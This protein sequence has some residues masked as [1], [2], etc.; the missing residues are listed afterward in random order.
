M[1]FRH[2]HIPVGDGSLHIAEA[3]DPHGRP[4]LFLH[5]WPQSWRA[6]QGVMRHAAPE[7]R[8]VAVDLPGIG[9]STTTSDGTKSHVAD[10]VHELVTAMG[11]RGATLVGHDAGGMAAYSYL[12]RYRDVARVAILDVVVPGVPP[13]EAVVR[14]PSV[15]HFGFHATPGLPETLTRGRQAVYFDHFFDI[16][17]VDHARITPQARAAYAAAYGSDAA[18][19]AGFDLYRAFPED[20]RHNA[21]YGASQPVATPLLYVRGEHSGGDIGAYAEGFHGAGITQL[22]TAV[23]P[24]S[25]HFVAEEAPAELWRLLRNWADGRHSGQDLP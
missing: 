10:L 12:R 9:E 11:L 21:A 15:W 20:A 5:G 17:T 4:F 14:N 16:L 24:G 18:L 3:G 8:A 13:W 2:S 22:T 6:W 25:G 19:T 23:V 7:A 1:E